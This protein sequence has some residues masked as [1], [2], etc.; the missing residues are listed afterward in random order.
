MATV[1]AAAVSVIGIA[2]GIGY[3]EIAGGFGFDWLLTE[4][5][6]WYVGFGILLHAILMGQ[7]FHR[8]KWQDAQSVVRAMTRS[9][10]CP[11]CAYNIQGVDPE[12]D[13][14]TVCPECGAAWRLD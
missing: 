11:S 12:T 10:L 6:I 8:C 1:H 9:G 2:L 7:Y 13:G 14:C 4:P 5:T 3:M